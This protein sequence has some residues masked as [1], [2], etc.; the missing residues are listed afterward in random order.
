M[1]KVDLEKSWLA[2]LEQE[3]QQEYMLELRHFLTQ[4]TQTA[5]V[6]YPPVDLIFNALN[7]TPIDKVKVVILGQDPYH[8]TGQAHGL[9]FSVPRGVSPPPSLINIFKALKN[10]LGI[11]PPNHGCLQDW[12]AQGVLLLNAVLTV[13]HKKAGSH[14]SK[15]WELFTDTVVAELNTRREGLVFMLWGAY[16]QKKGAII[17]SSKHLVL[18]AAHPSPL[19]AYRGFLTCEHFSKANEYLQSNGVGEVDWRV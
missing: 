7:S 9:S 14:A 1:D 17:D 11:E 3:F 15:G 6:F 16:A 19:S 4:Q 2:A 18:K 10:D 8:G 5:K 12:A 13:E